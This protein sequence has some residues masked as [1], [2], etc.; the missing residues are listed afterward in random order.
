LYDLPHSGY[1]EDISNGN[2][3]E[4][5]DL[6][7]PDYDFVKLINKEKSHSPWKAKIYDDFSSKTHD[8]MKKLI[9]FTFGKQHKLQQ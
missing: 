3:V 6:F 2:W 4:D 7:T 5:F 8:H 1:Y 9:G